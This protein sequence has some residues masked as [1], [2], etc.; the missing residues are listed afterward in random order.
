MVGCQQLELKVSQDLLSLLFPTTFGSVSHQDLGTTS[1][2]Y[3]AQVFLYTIPIT[4]AVAGIHWIILHPAVICWIVFTTSLHSLQLGSCCLWRTPASL[5]LMLKAW[6]CAAII[7]ASTLPFR[8]VFFSNWWDFL[9]TATLFIYRLCW[10]LV[11]HEGSSS[12]YSHCLSSA[13]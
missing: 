4:Y 13:A 6:C 9:M 3:A 7:R 12:C 2:L 8:L 5:D 11:L 10:D 1:G